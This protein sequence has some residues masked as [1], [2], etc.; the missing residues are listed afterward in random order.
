M[1][2][3]TIGSII[4]IGVCLF[5][6]FFLS[7]MEAGLFALSRVRIRYLEKKGDPRARLL[8]QYLEDP[9]AFLWTILIGNTVAAFVATV[10]AF[11][12]LRS[13]LGD[14]PA[15]LL[16]VLV[17]CGFAYFAFV[18]LMPKMLFQQFP[19]RLCLAL[20]KPFRWVK[21]LLAPMV[22]PV[23]TVAKFAIRL[24]GDARSEGGLFVNKNELRLMMQEPSDILTSEEKVLISRVLDLE[25]LTVGSR[26]RPIDKVVTLE[27]G[28]TVE[29]V[30]RVCRDNGL[31]RV[32]IWEKVGAGRRINRYVY[33]M[34][35]LFSA[36]V[37]RNER[38]IDH[39]W[40]VLHLAENTRLKDAL[41]R[42]QETGQHIAI[43]TNAERKE[44][45][46]ISLQDVLR[47]I[48]GE[49]RI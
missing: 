10:V 17:I 43:V 27:A 23:S 34:P 29:D 41:R 1:T 2:D 32:P 42:M 16:G 11:I 46:I 47:V 14:Q 3:A 36:T 6:S 9:E 18:E 28:A 24:W 35:L 48:F 33:L 8:N 30:L 49:V 37:R 40:P 38:A 19:N 25:N 12:E 7:G 20:V 45:G 13:W 44:R 39:S 21:G 31:N 22:V 5:V 4:L 15:M 26:C